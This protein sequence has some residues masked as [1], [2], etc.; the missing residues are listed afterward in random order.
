MAAS[1]F[2]SCRPLDV[3]FA[4]ACGRM[5]L[6]SLY[7]QTRARKTAKRYVASRNIMG[8]IGSFVPKRTQ[9]NVDRER[10]REKQTCLFHHLRVARCRIDLKPK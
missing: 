2:L 4:G 5:P 3:C 10:E 9:T 8:G 1:A 7:A 6:L